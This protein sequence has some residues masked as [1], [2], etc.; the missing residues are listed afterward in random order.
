MTRPELDGAYNTLQDE[1]EFYRRSIFS[2]TQYGMWATGYLVKKAAPEEPINPNPVIT[3]PVLQEIVDRLPL[4]NYKDVRKLSF[5]MKVDERYERAVSIRMYLLH[6]DFGDK[7]KLFNLSFQLSY[8][9]SRTFAV[10][11]GERLAIHMAWEKIL[12]SDSFT[13]DCTYGE[14]ETEK[15]IGN[16]RKAN[17][18]LSDEEEMTDEED[19][20]RKKIVRK[21]WRNLD[22]FVSL[23]DGRFIY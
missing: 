14:A 15:S 2:N 21:H 1:V 3:D 18:V 9:L 8:F 7:L 16:R 10:M 13:I 12:F 22:R 5:F 11:R 4:K 6:S 23:L 19:F 17:T 20:S